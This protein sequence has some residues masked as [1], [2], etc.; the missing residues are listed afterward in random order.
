MRWLESSSPASPG[1]RRTD[2]KTRPV[3]VLALLAAAVLACGGGTDVQATV[4]AV[5]T[6]VELTLGAMTQPPGSPAPSSTP[7]ATLGISPSPAPGTLP[8]PTSN[9]TAAPTAAPNPTATPAGLERPNGVLLHASH[10]LSPPTIDAQTGDWPSPLPNAID[11]IVF[12]A[13]NWSGLADQSGSFAYAWDANNLYLLVV[14]VDDLH[15]QTAHG[16]LLFRGDSLEL[17]FDADL[18]GDFTSADLSGD[19]FQLGLSPGENRASPEAYLWNPAGR[20]GIPA[21]LT[22]SSRATDPNGG[23]VF[24]AALP[25]SLFAVTPGAGQHFGLAFNSSDDDSPGTAQQ[26]SMISSVVTRKLLDPT[27]WG[28]LQL[29]P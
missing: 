7:Q 5:N 25:W 27:S 4:N 19:D 13:S 20:K 17:Q 12:Q 16:E 23:Y 8:A 21:G 2:I 1:L 9:P 28:T 22:L 10:A 29:D 15:V 3:W 6:A 11:Q 18:P 14:V 26:Q 24:E